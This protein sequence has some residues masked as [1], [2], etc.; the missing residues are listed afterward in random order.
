MIQPYQIERLFKSVTGLYQKMETDLVINI[1]KSLKGEEP[2]DMY[3]WQL[4]KLAQ[5]GQ[6]RKSNIQIISRYTKRMPEEIAAGFRSVGYKALEDDERKYKMAVREKVLEVTPLPIDASPAIEQIL[7]A[8]INNAKNYMNLTNTTALQASMAEYTNIVN[9]TYLE[10]MTG[11]DSYYNSVRKGVIE[12]ADKGIRTVTYSG[13][14][15]T[16]VDVALRRN[17]LTSSAQMVGRM[18]TQ[19]A[20]EYGANLVE[21]SSHADARPEHAEWQ[22][23]IYS[24]EGGTADYPNLAAA[25][26]YGTGEGLM[27]WNCRHVFYPYFE[28]LSEQVYERYNE[29]EVEQ[30]YEDSQVQRS[31]ERDIRKWTRRE[32]AADALGDSDTAARARAKVEEKTK[33]YEAFSKKVGRTMRSERAVVHS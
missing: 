33:E 26:G 10:T 29:E 24:L 31:I 32:M 20:Q 7:H 23:Q 27:G 11:I 1:A 4:D 2:L 21:V 9:Q 6:L 28:G 12:L 14:R 22:G 3:L 18:Q 30:A 17:I 13:G 25:T 15:K 8:A 5:L 19:R 16:Q